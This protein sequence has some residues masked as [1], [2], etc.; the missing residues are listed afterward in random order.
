MP[1]LTVTLLDE[2][3]GMQSSAGAEVPY[4]SGPVL[5][6]GEDRW[7]KQQ[8]WVE[9]PWSSTQVL[10]LS[11]RSFGHLRAQVAGTPLEGDS[12][13][14]SEA[15]IKASL[16][17]ERRMAVYSDLVRYLLLHNYGGLWCRPLTLASPECLHVIFYTCT[18][19]L[20]GRITTLCM[21]RPQRTLIMH[22]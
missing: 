10:H 17:K 20:Y 15:A 6:E 2:T 1:C 14:G 11:M 7:Q 19:C 13:F 9:F 18:V 4:C 12:Y 8:P 5:A 3:F 21:G 22:A 16:P